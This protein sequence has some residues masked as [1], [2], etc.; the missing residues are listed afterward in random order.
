[1]QLRRAV[2]T[3]REQELAEGKVEPPDHC[4]DRPR[5]SAN[6]SWRRRGRRSSTQVL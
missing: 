6:C 1:M 3:E 2:Q 5:F 4:G